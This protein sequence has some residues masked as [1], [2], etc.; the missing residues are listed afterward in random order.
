MPDKNTP[1]QSA[2]FRDPARIPWVWCVYLILFI[3][4]LPLWPVEGLIL[5]LP[6]WAVL[7]ILGGGVIALFTIYVL[8]FVWRDDE[9]KINARH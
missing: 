2:R 4:I 3:A 5:G 1:N 6:S 9:E 7:T 8:L